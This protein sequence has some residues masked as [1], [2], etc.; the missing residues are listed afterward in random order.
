[1][2]VCL[3]VRIIAVSVIALDLDAQPEPN[4]TIRIMQVSL[5]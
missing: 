5:T 1:M 3:N 2:Y 4:I